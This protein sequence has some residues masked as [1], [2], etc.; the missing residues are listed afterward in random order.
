MSL[1]AQMEAWFAEDGWPFQRVEGEDALVA[2]FHGDRAQAQ[3]SVYAATLEA[4]Q[5]VVLYSILPFKA[6]HVDLPAV[7]ELLHRANYG[8]LIGNFELDFTDGEIRYKTSLD[9][10]GDR[11][12]K[13]LWMQLLT[14]NVLTVDRYFAAVREVIQLGRSPLEALA[15][16]EGGVA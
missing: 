4:Q 5:R 8:M 13:A 12:T 2:L 1:F 15:D 6:R 14:A 11:L 10:E 7:A 16:L 9:V 3:W